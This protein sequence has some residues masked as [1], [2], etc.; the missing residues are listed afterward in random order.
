MGYANPNDHTWHSC[1]AWVFFRIRVCWN[2]LRFV[3][4]MISLCCACQQDILSKLYHGCQRMYKPWNWE[5]ICVDVVHQDLMVAKHV[6]MRRAHLPSRDLR[7][8]DPLLSYPSSILGRGHAIVVNLEHIKTIITAQEVFLLDGHNPKVV[9]F[10]E[11]LRLRLPSNQSSQ[12]G[13]SSLSRCSLCFCSFDC[14]M[15]AL[16]WLP[17]CR[18]L[19]FGRIS[20][21]NISRSK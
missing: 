19:G 5:R 16:A 13:P 2:Y 3:Q 8:L 12:V 14:Q 9:P 17:Q 1:N 11:E 6:I 7:L 18:K 21:S 4:C 10:V 15:Q 20:C